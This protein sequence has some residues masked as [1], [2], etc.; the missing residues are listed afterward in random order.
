MDSSEAG[1]ERY[2][3]FFC[4]EEE[5]KKDARDLKPINLYKGKIIGHLQQKHWKQQ[6]VVAL[7]ALPA[8]KRKEG[9]EMS[10][11]QKLRQRLITMIKD[12]G[13]FAYNPSIGLDVSEP[14]IP[15]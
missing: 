15:A 13:S 7:N 1:N 12:K 3:C 4:I 6:E 10:L 2:A 5:E 9:E 11:G 14:C 8:G